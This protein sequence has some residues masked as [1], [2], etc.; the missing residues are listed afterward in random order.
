MGFVYT[1]DRSAVEEFREN[2]T[3]LL[4]EPNDAVVDA[5]LNFASR[6]IARVAG[7][8]MT[9]RWRAEDDHKKLVAR[10]EALADHYAAQVREVEDGNGGPIPWTNTMANVVAHIRKAVAEPKPPKG[11]AHDPNEPSSESTVFIPART[12]GDVDA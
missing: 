3:E 6:E 10:V 8:E 4:G 12:P 11:F 5:L 7:G 1:P 2:V 9:A